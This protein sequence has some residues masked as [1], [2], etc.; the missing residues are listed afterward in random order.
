[1]LGAP[2]QA[3][4]L[5]P[6]SDQLEHPVLS[7]RPSACSPID[8]LGEP[9]HRPLDI[10]WE[11]SLA[12]PPIDLLQGTLDVLVLKTLSWGPRHG[13]AVARGLQQLTDDV[14]QIEEGS[15]YPALHRMERRGWV[16]SEWGLSENNRRA[17][18]Y[19][20]TAE[21]RR[22]L[23]AESSTWS[24][25]SLAVSLV[26]NATVAPALSKDLLHE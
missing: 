21:G 14:L 25:F 19:K 12:A 22:Q 9:G 15:L 3:E 2:F 5:F 7:F 10:L 26:L 23:R 1:M 8:I 24:V 4:S 13:Y 6:S 20:L 16:A 11:P 17:K 18:Y